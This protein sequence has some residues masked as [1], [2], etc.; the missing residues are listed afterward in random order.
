MNQLITLSLT[1]LIK[2]FESRD[3]VGLTTARD[4]LVGVVDVVLNQLV[5]EVVSVLRFLSH[6]HR[7]PL[8]K[9]LVVAA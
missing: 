5:P 7:Q 9:H 6:Q 1:D 4:V 2:Y 3:P 8:D